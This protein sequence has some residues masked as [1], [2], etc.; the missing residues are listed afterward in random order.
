MQSPNY[1]NHLLEM[2]RGKNLKGKRK[3]KKDYLLK[4]FTGGRDRG[5]GGE[6]RRK[7]KGGGGAKGKSI[8]IYKITR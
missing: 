5:R 4:Y 2:E 7:K 8:L 6:G 1:A 3:G